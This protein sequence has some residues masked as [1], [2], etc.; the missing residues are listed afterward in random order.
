MEYRV[1][2]AIPAKAEYVV[3]ARLTLV[4][5]LRPRG[6]SDDAIDDLKL[7]LTEACSESVRR[8]R[9]EE[10]EQ[11]YLCFALLD[12][13]AIVQVSMAT[14]RCSVDE[15]DEGQPLMFTERG[16][17]IA[18]IRAM[19]DEFE[20]RLSSDDGATLLFTKLCDA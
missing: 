7:A 12:D 13:R 19:A 14:W 4:G 1:K 8:S 10:G 6:Y 3:L 11:I 2:L 16:M 20:L 18:L 5:L 17:R 9:G 15:I